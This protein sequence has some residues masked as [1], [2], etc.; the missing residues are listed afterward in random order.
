MR[1]G[2]LHREEIR[3]ETLARAA[4]RAAERTFIHNPLL[5]I[6]AI[7]AF[8]TMFFVPPSPAYLDYFDWHTLVCLF[9]ILSVLSAI[10]SCGLLEWTAHS[11]AEHATST[12]MLVVALVVATLGCSLVLSNDMTLL[13]VL[14]L[15]LVLLKSVNREREVPLAFI[16]ITLTANLGGMLLPFGNPHNLYLFSVFGVDFSTFVLA[17]AAPLVVSVVLILVCCLGVKRSEFHYS[18][19]E[20]IKLSPRHVAL[21][22]VLFAIC[23]A[24]TLNAVNYLLGAVVV[25]VALCVDDHQAFAK[26]D[27]TLILTFVFF[28]VFTGNISNIPAVSSFFEMLLGTFGAFLTTLVSSQVISNLPAAILVSHFSG[29]W[30]AIALGAN[31]G[32]IGTPI[33]SLATLITLRQYQKSGLGHN[34]RFLARFEAFN[35]AF[36][37]VLAAFEMLVMGVR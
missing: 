11:I 13:T 32:G 34:G 22:L 19:P 28:F 10:D 5:V 27:Y 12:R 36:L 1:P 2:A 3:A 20:S 4:E 7:A 18:K 6:S 31:I 35:F 21:Y 30:A 14:P 33:S 26:T 24:I 16:L 15:A 9:C 17:M 37:V 8:A 23:I 25:I 29:N